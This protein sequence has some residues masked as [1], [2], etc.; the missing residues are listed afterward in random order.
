MNSPRFTPWRVTSWICAGILAISVLLCIVIAGIKSVGLTGVTITALD[1]ANEPKDPVLPLVNQH[2]ALPDYELAIVRKTDGTIRLGTKPDTSAAKGLHWQI[3][4]PVSVADIASLRLTEQDKIV[5]DVLAEV[6]VR[7]RSV[8]ENGYRFEFEKQRSVGV[9][10]EAFFKT[11]I[12]LAIL[13]AVV[14]AVLV[15]IF[16]QI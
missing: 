4:D 6:Q 13:T 1:P 15:I 7:G 16:S 2:E 11:P 5:S 12:G 10:V 9:G 3:D 8:D 14:L